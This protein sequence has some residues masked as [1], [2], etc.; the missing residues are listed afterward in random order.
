M[1]I[2][3]KKQSKMDSGGII[4]C[5]DDLETA[6]GDEILQEIT[7]LHEKGHSVEEIS[8]AFNRDADEVFIG[9]FHQ[10][11]KGKTTRPFAYRKGQKA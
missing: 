11:R 4:Y 8:E 10:A 1:A 2:E 7:E 6:F 3:R 9:L 5:L